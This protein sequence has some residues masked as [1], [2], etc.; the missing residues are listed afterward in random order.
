MCATPAWERQ[1]FVPSCVQARCRRR[2]CCRMGCAGKQRSLAWK[3]VCCNIDVGEPSV[4]VS[5]PRRHKIT[6]AART[7]A[8][9][10]RCRQSGAKESWYAYSLASYWSATIR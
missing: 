6:A 2:P 1:L 4:E 8:G 5:P 3:S 9:T 10:R 7:R